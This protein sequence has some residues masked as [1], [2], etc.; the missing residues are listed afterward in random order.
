MPLSSDTAAVAAPA[1]FAPKV[2]SPAPVALRR[3]LSVLS[4]TMFG[5]SYICPSVV[6]STFGVVAVRSGGAGALA[7]L[8]ATVAMV[9][10][11]ASYGRMAARYPESGS[12]YTYV[13]RTTN[14]TLGLVVGWV[15][16]LDY[17][18]IPT[19]I[20]LITAK[21]LEVLWPATSF[22]F[23]IFGVA[24]VATSINLLGI[25]VADRVNL[26]IMSAQ[27]LAMGLLMFICSRYLHA[28]G[29]APAAAPGSAVF[30]LTPFHTSAANLPL[31]MAGAAIACYSFLGFDAVSTLS[32]E[33][34]DPTRN[35]PRATILAAGLA[36]LIFVGTV[37]LM[38][39]AHPSLQFADVDNAG[40]A[41][42]Q[43]TTGPV[44]STAFTFVLIVS[45]LAAVVCAQAGCSRLLY[46][47]ARDTMLPK[48]FFGYLSPRFRVPT[49]SIGLMGVVML[50]GQWLDVDTATSCVNFGAFSAFLAVN[51][52]VVIDRV[53]GKRALNIGV[54]ALTV[55][56]VGAA[57]SM[58][59]LFSLS[60]TA[61]TV[62]LTWLVVGLVYVGLRSRAVRAPAS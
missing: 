56:L 43:T 62:G 2:D 59:L 26:A 11:A 13:A 60:R 39:L 57:A 5:L 8:I 49:L 37:Y 29:L 34:V 50:L 16:I 20:C 40:F 41:V 51:A 3:Q 42:L 14:P 48:P 19:V 17:F 55:A 6:V 53:G 28:T 61:L 30:T 45:N 12:A 36:G 15:L 31:A 32:E 52:C 1:G 54:L 33:T 7:Y 21:A 9:L 4:A 38:S 10:T 24:A 25:K 44:F 27:L 58:W 46:A 22:H 35:I 23:W 47:M 18:F